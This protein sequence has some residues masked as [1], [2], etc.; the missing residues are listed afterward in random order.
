[1]L[2]F[3]CW[4]LQVIAVLDEADGPLPYKVHRS[5]DGRLCAQPLGLTT[6]EPEHPDDVEAFEFRP[7]RD[8]PWNIVCNSLSR[9]DAGGGTPT[10]T[11]AGG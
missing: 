7:A 8:K 11:G 9:T 6:L 10:N 4:R 1:M 3:V 2:I 5:E